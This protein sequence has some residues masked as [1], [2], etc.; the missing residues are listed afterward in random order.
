[1]FGAQIFGAEEFAV[2]AEESTA[3]SRTGGGGWVYRGPVKLPVR[4]QP[5]LPKL[6]FKK[7]NP[8]RW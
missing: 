1:M 6:T 7:P 3:T 5:E 4:K 2:I 8:Y